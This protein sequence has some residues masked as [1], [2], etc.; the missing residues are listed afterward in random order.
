MQIMRKTQYVRE[1]F[2]FYV[3]KR[4][5]TTVAENF[6]HVRRKKILFLGEVVPVGKTL[7]YP[8]MEASVSGFPHIVNLSFGMPEKRRTGY[9]A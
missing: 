8:W 6:L 7:P 1:F 2:S 9:M 5:R 3:Q 4:G